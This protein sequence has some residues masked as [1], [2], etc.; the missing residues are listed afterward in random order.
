MAGRRPVNVN[1]Y[2]CTP[3]GKCKYLHLLAAAWMLQKTRLAQLQPTQSSSATFLFPHKIILLST[4][5]A[6]SIA[7][8]R[9]S[10]Q[11]KDQPSDFQHGDDALFTTRCCWH[12]EFPPQNPPQNFPKFVYPSFGSSGRR[13]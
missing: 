10:K 4:I 1:I 6:P 7:K 3:P 5:N 12:P 8:I 11:K 13:R 9:F 2:I